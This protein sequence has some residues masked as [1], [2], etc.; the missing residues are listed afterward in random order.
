MTDPRNR[1]SID[2]LHH[3]VDE[4]LWV[5]HDLDSFERYVEE[6]VGLDDLQPLVDERRR[7]GGDD[8]PHG[9]GRVSESLQRGDGLE[10]GPAPAT[11]R[12]AAGRDHELAN[13]IGRPT[14]Q[15]LRDGAVL[16]V[17]RDDLAWLCLLYTSDAA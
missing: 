15:A 16:A 1:G 10:C 4:G 2:A 13:L 9:P 8:R 12:P 11:K 7:V 14:A 3:R 6:Q 5:D 17:H